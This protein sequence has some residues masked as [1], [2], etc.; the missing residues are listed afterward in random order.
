MLFIAPN[1]HRCN[2][3]QFATIVFDWKYE[4]FDCV[5]SEQ[6]KNARA[7]LSV[8]RIKTT[9]CI[10]IYI[11]AG[12]HNSILISSSYCYIATLSAPV[13]QKALCTQPTFLLV[14]LVTDPSNSIGTKNLLFCCHG[15]IINH[16]SPSIGYCT[17]HGAKVVQ[18]NI[19]TGEILDVLTHI[20]R[21]NGQGTVKEAIL[22]P[23]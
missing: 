22:L 8:S 6:L 17:S 4:E 13:G 14:L 18:L 11:S 2:K 15:N 20:E 9:V 21:K 16:L 7:T 23:S 19:L 10:V 12:L 5:M 1:I 3:C